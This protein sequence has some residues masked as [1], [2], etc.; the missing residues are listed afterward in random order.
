[1]SIQTLSNA[2]LLARPELGISSPGRILFVSSTAHQ[3]GI[4]RASVRLAGD[5]L[6]LKRKDFALGFAC[7]PQSFTEELCVRNGVPVYPHRVRNSGDLLSIAGLAQI[8]CS[9]RAQIV[10]VHSRR[11][12]LPATLAVSLAHAMGHKTALFFHCHLVRALGDPP[13]LSGSYFARR[14]DRFLAVSQSVQ[15]HLLARHPGLNADQVVVLPNSVDLQK[16]ADADSN[17]RAAVR[18]KCGIPK[19]ATVIGMVGRLDAKGQAFLIDIAPALRKAITG[20]VRFLFVGGEGPLGFEKTLR[21]L[22]RQRGAEEE[23]VLTGVQ[24][25]VAPFF[26]AM[27]LFAHLPNDEAFGLAIAEAMAARLPI[28]A[29]L[30]PGCREIVRDGETGYLV[31]VNDKR[32]LTEAIVALEQSPALRTKMGSAAKERVRQQYSTESQI[33]ALSAIYAECTKAGSP[34]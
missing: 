16:M 13:G 11:D 21:E 20:P 24:E 32:A 28:V 5:L 3:G 33:A 23:M 1:Q 4:E 2:F 10:H 26:G 31:D 19:D 27:D 6:R 25:N 34:A 15:A 22:A 14:V 30:A 17:M 9:Y 29:S 8:I 12:Y 18:E 7:R